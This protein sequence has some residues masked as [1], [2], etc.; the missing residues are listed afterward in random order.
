[1][2]LDASGAAVTAA[3]RRSKPSGCDLRQQF[4]PVPE[5]AVG[6]IVRDTGAA[7]DL[8]QGE[9]ARPGFRGQ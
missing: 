7:G 9:A 4:L 3:V 8:A 5:V 2:G 1:M 6:G